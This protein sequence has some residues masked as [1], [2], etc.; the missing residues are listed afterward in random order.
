M[1]FIEKRARVQF[2]VLVEGL[3]F[4]T[5]LDMRCSIF[6]RDFLR[7]TGFKAGAAGTLPTAPAAY[8]L[9]ARL[10]S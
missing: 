5:T 2:V 4:G 10:I 3:N 6:P 8:R 1:D 7:S 9:K